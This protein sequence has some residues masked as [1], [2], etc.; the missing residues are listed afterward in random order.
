M[1]I[2][3]GKAFIPGLKLEPPSLLVA[4]GAFLNLMTVEKTGSESIDGG[5]VMKLVA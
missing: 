1:R 2:L 3:K 5:W 4:I